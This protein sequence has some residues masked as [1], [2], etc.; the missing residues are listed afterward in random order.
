M[1]ISSNLVIVFLGSCE[2]GFDIVWQLCYCS[3]ALLIFDEEQN[4]SYDFDDH[5]NDTEND[6]EVAEGKLSVGIW[7][8]G[9][10]P[11]EDPNHIDQNR[12]SHEVP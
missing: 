7:I 1:A 10:C 3:F 9:D 4:D 2:N 8:P 6:S 12:E 11:I 5:N